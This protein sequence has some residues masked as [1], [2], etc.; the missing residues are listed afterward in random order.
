MGY[1]NRELNFAYSSRDDQIIAKPHIKLGS[2]VGIGGRTEW[3]CSLSWFKSNGFMQGGEGGFY[4]LHDRDLTYHQA[5]SLA[6][7]WARELGIPFIR[8]SR[9]REILVWVRGYRRTDGQKRNLEDLLKVKSQ[10]GI[11]RLKARLEQHGRSR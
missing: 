5:Y 9:G 7:W 8:I 11:D 6:L 1:V 2:A 10:R 4:M 3:R